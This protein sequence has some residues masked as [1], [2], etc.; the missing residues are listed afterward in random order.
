MFSL[1][2]ITTA[3]FIGSDQ[4]AEE[5]HLNLNGLT[6]ICV[7]AYTEKRNQILKEYTDPHTRT[8][9]HLLDKHISLLFTSSVRGFIQYLLIECFL[10]IKT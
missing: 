7:T 4:I 8:P 2:I 6:D 10:V 3:S 9:K 5:F 1:K